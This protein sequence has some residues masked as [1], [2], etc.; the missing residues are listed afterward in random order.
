M[1][2]R[3]SFSNRILRSGRRLITQSIDICQRLATHRRIG[4]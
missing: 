3:G 2:E 1:A 4:V